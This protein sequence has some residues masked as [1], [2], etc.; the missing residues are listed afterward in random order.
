MN[1]LG[2]HAL[3]WGVAN[4][5]KH[6]PVHMCCHAKIGRSTSK[7]VGISRGTGTQNIVEPWSL[8]CGMGSA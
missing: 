5:I 1:V 7:G 4:P 2:L 3:G 6:V 8:P